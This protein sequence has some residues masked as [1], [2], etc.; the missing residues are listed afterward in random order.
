MAEAAFRSDKD[1]TKDGQ[2]FFE[3]QLYTDDLDPDALQVELF[4]DGDGGDHSF[5]HEMKRISQPVGT[6][7]FH[8]FGANVPATR[9]AAAYTPRVIPKLAGVAIPMEVAKILWQR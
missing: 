5:R 6:P 1:R 7:T 2:H 9:P 4:A 3:A 8:V